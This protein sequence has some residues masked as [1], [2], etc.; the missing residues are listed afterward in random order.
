MQDV[1][2]AT[3]MSIEGYLDVWT[4]LGKKRRAHLERDKE[5]ESANLGIGSQGSYDINGKCGGTRGFSCHKF[6]CYKCGERGHVFR[7]CKKD[8]MSFHC[9]QSVHLKHDCPTWVAEGVQTQMPTI[10]REV[11]V[12]AQEISGMKF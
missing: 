12:E 3:E 6:K 4:R 8:R 10:L 11:K 1:R 2:G 7:D 9:H 5:V